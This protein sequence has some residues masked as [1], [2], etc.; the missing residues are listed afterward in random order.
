MEQ[1]MV[2]LELL[3]ETVDGLPRVVEAHSGA[4]E[5]YPAAEEPHPWAMEA[6]IQVFAT[7]PGA[8]ELRKLSVYS[9]RLTQGK[10]PYT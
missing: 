5:A 4:V 8:L 9:G 7:H 10:W 3:S 6:L 2:Y 1:C